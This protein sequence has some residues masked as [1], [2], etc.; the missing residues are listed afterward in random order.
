MYEGPP[1]SLS[2]LR[3]RFQL[4]QDTFIFP[5][6]A[7]LKGCD[8]NALLRGIHNVATHY[9]DCAPKGFGNLS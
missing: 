5:V 4:Q 7:I 2:A 9:I 8:R 3:E 6:L 1:L